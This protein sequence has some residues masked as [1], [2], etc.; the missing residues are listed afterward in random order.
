MNTSVVATFWALVTILITDTQNI[1]IR[2]AADHG[3]DAFQI[4]I[5]RAHV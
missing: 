1:T 2:L 5:G 3:A 4:E